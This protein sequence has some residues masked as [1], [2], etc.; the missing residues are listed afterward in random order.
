MAKKVHRSV[1]KT[2]TVHRVR[3]QKEPQQNM[4]VYVVMYGLAALLL[5]IT[6]IVVN[7]RKAMSLEQSESV[8]GVHTQEVT[9]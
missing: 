8:L 5:L 2:H 6:A 3:M 9:K 4:F 7:N 1:K